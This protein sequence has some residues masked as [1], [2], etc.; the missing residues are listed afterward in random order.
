MRGSA[1]TRARRNSRQ[2]RRWRRWRRRKRRRR[3]R[4]RMCRPSPKLTER[5]GRK[6][7]DCHL[8]LTTSEDDATVDATVDVS[9][10]FSFRHQF[11]SRHQF[12]SQI[13]RYLPLSLSQLCNFVLRLVYY[14][15]V[16]FFVTILLFIRHRCHLHSFIQA[17]SI[18]PLQVHYYSEAVPTQH[19]YCA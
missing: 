6:L 15:F 2:R 5:I 10:S 9:S 12:L 11:F 14:L 17:I 8:A 18:A 1:R 3:N 16:V 4:R 7:S 19:G 13:L